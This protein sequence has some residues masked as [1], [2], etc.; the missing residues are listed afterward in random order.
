[1]SSMSRTA[2]SLACSMRWQAGRPGIER[3]HLVGLEHG[4]AQLCIHY[5]PDTLTLDRV[6][7]LVQ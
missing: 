1:M 3:A 4:A 5:Q 6:R 7:E 2:V